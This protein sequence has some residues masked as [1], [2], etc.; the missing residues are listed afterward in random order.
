MNPP[1]RSGWAQPPGGYRPQVDRRGAERIAT[2]LCRLPGDRRSAADR[3]LF[4]AAADDGMYRPTD[5]RECPSASGVRRRV[6]PRSAEPRGRRGGVDR[7]GEGRQGAR[8]GM[9]DRGGL[10]ID[11]RCVRGF[12]RRSAEAPGRVYRD[13]GERGGGR[14]G[15]TALSA[16]GGASR[17]SVSAT[18]TPG[19]RPRFHRSVADGPRPCCA[20]RGRSA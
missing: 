14:G 18:Q 16:R 3:A 11:S 5:A 9:D 19:R 10:R 7:G 15:G 1:G 8:Q 4:V 2:S 6:W 20:M 13:S 17:A 12:S